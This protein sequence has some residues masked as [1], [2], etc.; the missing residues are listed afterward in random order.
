VVISDF[1]RQIAG[2][3]LDVGPGPPGAISD[4]PLYPLSSVFGHVRLHQWPASLPLGWGQGGEEGIIGSD[5][6][7]AVVVYLF[8]YLFSF[9]VRTVPS[10]LG[11]RFRPSWAVGSVRLSGRFRPPLRSVPSAINRG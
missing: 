10:V 6:N 2:P 8:I 5:D 11:G 1:R 9:I 3:I 7:N 4:G